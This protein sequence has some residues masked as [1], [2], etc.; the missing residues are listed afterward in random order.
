MH[1]A[2]KDLNRKFREDSVVMGSPLSYAGTDSLRTFTPVVKT[3]YL[4]RGWVFQTRMERKWE[5]GVCGCY[6]ASSHYPWFIT[7]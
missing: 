2:K 6:P 5:E 7:S 4:E 3:D 1:Q